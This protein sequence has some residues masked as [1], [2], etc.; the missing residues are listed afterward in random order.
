MNQEAQSLAS[1]RDLFFTETSAFSGDQVS[2]LL[3]GVGEY[4]CWKVLFV[5]RLI[6]SKRHWPTAT[7][8]QQ[9]SVAQSAV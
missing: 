2:A 1:D 4:K 8:E 7:R 5:H 9:I 6:H 3:L